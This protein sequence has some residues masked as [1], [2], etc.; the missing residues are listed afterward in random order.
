MLRRALTLVAAVLASVALSA[1]STAEGQ[2]AQEL[3]LQAQAAEAQLRTAAFDASLSFTLS[4]QKVEVLLEGAGSEK[5][6]YVSMR[7]SGMPG[8][9]LDAELVVR[10]R[11][12]WVGLNGDWQRTAVPEGVDLGG[13]VSLGSAAF[14]ELTKHVK[15]VRV[16]EQQLV[17]GKPVTIIAGEI[18][19]VGL[20]G[21]LTKLAGS[22]AAGRIRAPRT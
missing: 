1:C 5:A 9:D 4:G 20:I 14:Q 12:A 10:G 3:L 13:S 21:S 7:A 19:T 11:T 22:A 15:D 17:G 6:Q 16:S 18:D 2:R 8:L